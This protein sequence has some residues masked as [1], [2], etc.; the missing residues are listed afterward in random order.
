MKARRVAAL[1]SGAVVALS[2]GR[3][4]AVVLLKALQ[5]ERTPII[6]PAPVLAEV[7]RGGR[8][9]AAVHRVLSMYSD[10]IVPT[11][12]ASAR[13]AGELLGAAKAGSTLTVDALIAA[14]A[15]HH[16]ATDLLTG[17]ATDYGRLAGDV[18]DI[19]PL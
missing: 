11:N 5:Q 15:A 17:D 9:D 19:I 16:G 8:G 10:D 3:R 14:T 6:I 13:Y 7:L 12:A 2:K 1:D 4:D 18:L